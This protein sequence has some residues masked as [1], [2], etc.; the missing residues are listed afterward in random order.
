MLDSLASIDLSVLNKMEKALLESGYMPGT[1]PVPVPQSSPSKG[2]AA[3]K[4]GPSKAALSSSTKHLPSRSITKPVSSSVV[5]LSQPP[6]AILA[7]SE[8]SPFVIPE[9]P[10]TNKVPEDD[11]LAMSRV[12]DTTGDTVKTV[13]PGAAEGDSEV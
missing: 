5:V 11:E 4:A 13:G 9:M 8:P 10:D 3:P 1:L 7:I 6:V 12:E 2:A